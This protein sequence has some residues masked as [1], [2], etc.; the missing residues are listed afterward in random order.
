MAASI[1]PPS[2][3]R[4]HRVE[5]RFLPRAD[6]QRGGLHRLGRLGVRRAV[7][8][9]RVQLAPAQV[10]DGRVVGD[11]EDPGR[12]LEFRTV[13]L[14]GVERLDEGLLRQILR[15][16]PVAHHAVEQGEDRP[17]V[18]A[19]QLPVGRLAARRGRA[20]RPPDR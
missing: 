8:R 4:L 20:G 9:E 19:D 5:R 1:A 6:L 14:D 16:L 13:G 7:E 11:L 15:Q 3:L 2:S 18:A 12:E 17:L 10:I